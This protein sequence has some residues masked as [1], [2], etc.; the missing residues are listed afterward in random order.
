LNPAELK[1][2][3]LCRGALV[4]ESC[5]IAEDGR[6]IGPNSCDLASGLEL[7]LPG[8]M[9]E[10]WVNV[11]IREKSV[12]LTPYRLTCKGGAYRIVD[13]RNELS[14][15][16]KL[17]PRAEW[18]SQVTRHGTPMI[19]IGMLQGTVLWIDLGESD[20]FWCRNRNGQDGEPSR[21]N[22]EC[23]PGKLVEDVVET[24]AVAQRLS[25]ITMVML[26]GRFPGND[27]LVGSFP[28]IQALK[29][30]VGIL[31]GLQVPPEEDL[32]LYD[33]AYALGVDHFSFYLEFFSQGA[34]DRLSPGKVSAHEPERARTALEHCVR[35]LGKGRVSGELI[36]GVEPTADTLRAID[37]LAGAGA[38]PLIGIYRPLCGTTLE[39]AAPPDAL[40]MTGIFRHIYQACRASH[41][42]I[43]IVPNI[44]LSALPHPVDT[45]YLAPDL[46]DCRA[47]QNW[48]TTMQ[49]MMRP[50]FLR[51]MR[52]HAIPQN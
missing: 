16:V 42:P 50:Y 47:Y 22:T 51:R 8:D 12:A 46:L 19:K 40:E 43:G 48:I 10:L 17:A 24:A 21:R 45:L 15:R 30:E 18:Y 20:R 35:L 4:D 7:I 9:R 49:Q 3:L 28:Y 38:L 39:N 1:I 2:E 14:Y 32:T 5:S 44:Q 33:Q 31:V 26:R 13:V 41:L 34:L 27:S 29:Q 37:Y 36:A 52:K 6:I 25:G 23:K 11:P